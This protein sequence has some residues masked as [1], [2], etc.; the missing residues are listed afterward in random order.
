MASESCEPGI[1]LILPH[2]VFCWPLL[3]PQNLSAPQG[4][5]TTAVIYY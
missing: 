3:A 4:F 1:L 2:A 5:K